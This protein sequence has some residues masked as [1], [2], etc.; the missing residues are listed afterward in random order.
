MQTV[1][2]T[3]MP[4]LLGGMLLAQAGARTGFVSDESIRKAARLLNRWVIWVAMPT[5]VMVKIHSLPDFSFGD[6]KVWLPV[7]QP[8]LHFAIV[9]IGL[10]ALARARSWSR[11]L[12]GAMILTVGLGNTSFVG[13]PLLNAILGPTAIPTAILLDQWGSFL[14]LT[15][16]GM[17]VAHAFS[18]RPS[19]RTPLLPPAIDWIRRPLS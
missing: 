15:T 5:L 6:P 8:W 19:T 4:Y 11:P 16:L 1:L 18:P 13:I 7:A 14:V 9:F 2:T 3:L 10:R 12:A 17:T